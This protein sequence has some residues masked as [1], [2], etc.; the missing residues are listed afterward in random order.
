[1][2]TTYLAYKLQQI[3]KQL[4][5]KD[6]WFPSSKTCS[7]CDGVKQCLSLSDRAYICDCGVILDQNINAAINIKNQG[8]RMLGIS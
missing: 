8:M 2:F 1:M 7:C 6:K 5:K 3:G 4:M